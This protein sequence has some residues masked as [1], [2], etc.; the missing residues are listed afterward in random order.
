MSDNGNIF[1]SRVL[2]NLLQ[3]WE[4][5]HELTC[6]Y[7]PQGNG[8]VERVHRTVKRT[9]K[10]ANCT[11]A[12]A[13][14]WVNNTRDERARSPFEWVFAARPRKPG[15][16]VARIEVDRPPSIVPSDSSQDYVDCTRN[17][18]VVGD[19]VYLRQPGGRCD[20]E[21][22]GTHRVTM[23]RPSVSVVLDD[24]NVSRHVSH[25]RRVPQ[26]RHLPEAASSDIS[27]D[28][29]GGWW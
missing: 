3:D 9:V 20:Q 5:N 23:L 27:D 19:S 28:K 25:L 15:V 12:E 2:E 29:H 7:R 24:D 6:A 18:F 1:H 14:F 21:W 4:V 10:R 13:V 8:I 22:S 16:S 17:P 11:V 26:P